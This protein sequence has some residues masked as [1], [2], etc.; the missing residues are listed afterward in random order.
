MANDKDFIVKNAVEVG[1]S[2]KTTL[3]TITSGTV[4]LSTGNYFSETLAANTTYAFSNAGDV[5]SFQLEVTG[6]NAAD[7][8]TTT[9]DSVSFSASS[10][11]ATCTGLF[12]KPDGT[13]MYVVGGVNNSIFQYTLSTAWDLSTAS[14]AS[15]SFNVTSQDA[16]PNQV[17]FKSDGTKMY[18][19]GYDSDNVWQYSLSTAWDV[20][21][22][23]YDSVS[24]SVG[25]QETLPKGLCFNPNGTKLYITGTA[26]DK[27]YQYTLSTAWDLSTASYD[28][29]N[30]SVALNPSGVFIN[31]DGTKIYSVDQTNDDVNEY[32]L[33]TPFDISTGGS[34]TATISVN[35]Q[36]TSAQDLFFSSDFTKMYMIGNSTDS[37]YQYSVGQTTYTI[38]WPTSI[39]WAGGVSPA[40]PATG[41]TDLFSISTDD[42]GTTY[43]GFKVADNLS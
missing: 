21:T 8:S 9:Y 28:S 7:F 41:E 4:D 27:I 19:I 14:Y 42:G 6:A 34:S 40:A 3:G 33:S 25:S 22:A 32:T 26:T 15:K 30:L 38:T 31:S 16:E 10:Q 12:F 29:K 1:G 37:V 43:Q 2:T 36:D 5:Q 11:D 17:W 23:S 35:G 39:E 13:T 24:F 18:M 20:S